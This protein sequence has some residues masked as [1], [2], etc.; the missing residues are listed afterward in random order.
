MLA[1]LSC[2]RFEGRRKNFIFEKK[3]LPKILRCS[4]GFV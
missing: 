4:D 2:F 3:E 1:E